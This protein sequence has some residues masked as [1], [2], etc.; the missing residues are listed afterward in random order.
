VPVTAAVTGT[1]AVTATL[2]LNT[3]GAT[4][5]LEPAGKLFGRG[6][7]GVALGCLLLFVVP[8]RRR[9][10]PLLVLV[11]TAGLLGVTG[12]AGSGGSGGGTPGNPGNPGTPAGSYT[13]TVTAASGSISTTASVVVTVQ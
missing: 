7:G 1:S 4:A 13:V 12:C 9:W 11:L 5:A 8:R 2:T 10:A 3:T 6:A